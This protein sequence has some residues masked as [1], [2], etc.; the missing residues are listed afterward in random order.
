VEKEPGVEEKNTQTDKHVV[1]FIMD[2]PLTTGIQQYTINNPSTLWCPE[3]SLRVF[4]LLDRPVFLVILDYIR[5][6]EKTC[7]V[8]ELNLN[9]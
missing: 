7:I 6:L 2:H 4:Y 9:V 5:E 8:V 1:V 3:A